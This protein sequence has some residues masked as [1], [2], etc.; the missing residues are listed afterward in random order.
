[1]L[2]PRGES[3]ETTRERREGLL[4]LLATRR[5]KLIQWGLQD[6]NLCRRSQRI[7]SPP[8]LTTRANPQ[9]IT[10]NRFLATSF[11]LFNRKGKSQRRDSNPRP[12][13]YKSAAL[14]TELRWP[15]QVHPARE[16]INRPCDG[17]GRVYR[18]ANRRQDGIGAKSG[19][20]QNSWAN[21]VVK[22]QMVHPSREFV[23]RIGRI[24][25]I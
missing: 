13:D 15:A 25:L 11:S 5:S 2:H 16:P 12:A 19:S 3:R 6:S 21:F 23:D 24:P 4:S 10:S 18:S 14:P 22:S 17:E 9:K 20:P 8:P 7:Y 1:M